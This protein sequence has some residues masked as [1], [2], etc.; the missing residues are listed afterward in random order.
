[1]FLAANDGY[2]DDND[3]LINVEIKTV[4]IAVDAKKQWQPTGVKL[5]QGDKY[6]IRYVSGK[7][8][9]NPVKFSDSRERTQWTWDDFWW[10]VDSAFQRVWLIDSDNWRVA[11]IDW[12]NAQTTDVGDIDR[13]N[14]PFYVSGIK[15]MTFDP[16]DRVVYVLTDG[17]GGI[18][19]IPI[20]AGDQNWTCKYLSNV[21]R[22]VTSLSVDPV[23]NKR[24][25]FQSGSNTVQTQSCDAT[26]FDAAAN[27]SSFNVQLGDNETASDFLFDLAERKLYVIATGN[28]RYVIRRTDFSGGNSEHLATVLME[29]M[30]RSWL[31][32]PE[33]RGIDYKGGFVFVGVKNEYQTYRFRLDPKSND[34]S[35]LDHD[36][37][38]FFE[39]RRK[40][41]YCQHVMDSQGF[42]NF[43]CPERDETS[44]ENQAVLARQ[45]A[46]SEKPKQIAAAHVK[47]SAATT[48]KTEELQRKTDDANRQRSESQNKARATVAQHQ[49]DHGHNLAVAQQNKRQKVSAANANAEKEREQAVQ[50]KKKKIADAHHQAKSLMDAAHKK[51][52]EAHC[53]QH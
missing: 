53:K 16:V 49:R 36:R 31:G 23:S 47:A 35:Q 45:R 8:S 5:E 21:S 13:G 34:L 24:L 48:A 26:A 50:A 41:D 39:N 3:G 2:F 29:D 12:M 20:Q 15:E 51:L 37:Y 42:L 10:F 22:D 1:M 33:L 6:T 27:L 17:D 43:H 40:Q 14:T 18:L 7:W 4:P 32:S 28:D 38:A 52:A 44:L 25:L 11:Y 9:A 46:A 30:N 19:R